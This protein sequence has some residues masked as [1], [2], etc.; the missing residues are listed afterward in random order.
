MR[1]ELAHSFVLENATVAEYIPVPV[2]SDW[3]SS[4]A[5]DVSI[6]VITKI[7]CDRNSSVSLY[8]NHSKKTSAEYV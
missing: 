1:K 8:K 4:K 6:N 5:S 2:K 3:S 7:F